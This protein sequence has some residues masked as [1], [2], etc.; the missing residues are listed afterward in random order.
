MTAQKDLKRLIRAR[1]HKTGESYTTARAQLRLSKR[2]S[3]QAAVRDTPDD[4][5]ACPGRHHVP[6]GP[7]QIDGLVGGRTGRSVF[8]RHQRQSAPVQG[9][10]VISSRRPACGLGMR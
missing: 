2:C 8:H 1:M 4:E 3:R 5:G 9:Q 10:L 6:T 7:C